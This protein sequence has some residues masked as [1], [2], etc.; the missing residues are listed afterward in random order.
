[1]WFIPLDK[2]KHIMNVTR[3]IVNVKPETFFYAPNLL[4][5]QE[6][7][8]KIKGFIQRELESRLYI[9]DNE[10]RKKIEEDCPGVAINTSEFTTYGLRNCLGYILRAEY[11]F[12]GSII[13]AYGR[14]V[15]MAEVFTEYCVYREQITIDELKTLASEMNVP[16]YWDVVRKHTVR[17]SEDIFLRED[18]INFDI[19]TTEDIL[20][21]LLEKEYVPLK[22]I[23]LF[24]HF[25]P[26]SVQWN[27]YVL[28][29]YL[30]K[31]SRKFRLLHTSFSAS[32]FFGAVVKADSPIE[33][34]RTLIIDVLVHS[35]QWMDAKDALNLLVSEGYQ[36]RRRYEDIDKVVH[37]AKLLR[38]RQNSIEK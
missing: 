21:S 15:N 1:M 29:S 28:E 3:S 9:T 32:G 13:S 11:Q 5:N 24:T 17:V 34:Y 4:V 27:G 12:N 36:Q 31:Y 14:E 37:E 2:V 38:E 25:P 20:E 23:G 18:Q 10:L 35:N 22:D 19:E 33:D 8:M 26:L 7:I 16:I 6:E 30:Y